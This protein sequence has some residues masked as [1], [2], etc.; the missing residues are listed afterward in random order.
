MDKKSLAIAYSMAKRA[1]KM[2]DGGVV[3]SD[4]NMKSKMEEHG[5]TDAADAWLDDPS[6]YAD[7]GQA[8]AYDPKAVP[9]PPSQSD[10]DKM[11]AIFGAEGGMACADRAYQKMSK[12]GM[13]A[14]GGDDDLDDMAD[15]KPNNFDD[16]ALRDDLE[17]SETAA[18]SGD[19]LG[20]AQE[21]E[22]RHDMVSRIM[23]SE[24]AKDK[25]PKAR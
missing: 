15:G 21:D 20:D 22:D 2:A 5:L 23:R 12:G 8:V 25:L 7:G 3:D 24:R 6:E 10:A 16:L 19:E 17:F 1:K 18:N 13:V 14:N 11:K 9:K 4:D